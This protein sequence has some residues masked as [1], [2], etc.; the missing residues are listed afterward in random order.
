[1]ILSGNDSQETPQDDYLTDGLKKLTQ[2]VRKGMNYEEVKKQM[3][4][5]A[6]ARQYWMF[7]YHDSKTEAKKN[8]AILELRRLMLVGQNNLIN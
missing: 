1:M 3:D 2:A 7:L 4:P 6:F 8:E 5:I